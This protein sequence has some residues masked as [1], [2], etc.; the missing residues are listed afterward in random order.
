MLA[1]FLVVVWHS[2]AL[3]F[4]ARRTSRLR[5]DVAEFTGG[6]G[7]RAGRGRANTGVSEILPWV[8]LM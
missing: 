8:H 2:N 3:T 6:A 7:A 1:H 4:G 5:N